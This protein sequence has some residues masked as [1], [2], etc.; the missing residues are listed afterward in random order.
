MADLTFYD[1]A[2]PPADPPPAD[3]VC[4]Y[5]GGDTPHVWTLEEIGMQAARFRLPVFVRSNPPGPGPAADVAA[6]VSRLRAIGAPK[7]TL[8]AWDME[9]A[10]DPVYIRGVSTG[11]KSAGYVLIIYGS[12]STVRGNAVADGLYFGADWTSVP[13]LH[14][15]DAMT[16]Y[17]S[18]SGFDEELAKPSL[19][20][21]DTRPPAPKPAPPAKA[22]TV[23]QAPR[24]W[25]TAGIDS[26]AA[27]AVQ[28][29][30]L[31][32]T[33]LRLTVQHGGPFD[34]ATAGYLNGVFSGAVD[35]RK[36]MPAGLR[37][38]VPG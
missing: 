21:W 8:V 22:P 1:A 38:W 25:T 18:F 31:P 11:L 19:P 20:F 4:L 24:P 26:L 36:P 29:R 5:I 12:E 10:A 35:P 28:Q 23:Q 15:G 14:S 7:G 30:S 32:S 2:F 27:L 16:Q 6:A 9:T 37:L 33:I 17:V 13:H 34:P 3:G